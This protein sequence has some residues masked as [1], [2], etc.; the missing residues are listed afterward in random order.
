VRDRI[1]TKAKILGRELFLELNHQ[2]SRTVLVLGSG[3]SGTTW[4]AESLAREHKSRLLFEPFHPLL[5]S[6]DGEPHLFSQPSGKGDTFEQSVE[7]VL[8]GRVRTVHV[9]QV[10]CARLARG[11]IVK[12]VHAANLLPWFRAGYPSLP[13]VFVLR[14]PIAASLSRLRSS[15]FYGLG[16]YLATPAGRADAE[17]SPVASWLP[18][19]D[20]HRAD[21]EP[22]VRLVAEWCIENVHPLSGLD[23]AGAALAFYEAIVISPVTELARLGEH[24]RGAL[25]PSNGRLTVSD[26]RQPSAM[27]WFG[28]AAAARDSD[29]WTQLLSRWT[30]EVPR[31]TVDRCLSVLSDFGL[32]RFYGDDPLPLSAPSTG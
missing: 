28:S 8:S 10:V 27:D 22:L 18:L 25:G 4:L 15:A 20:R 9:D 3:R 24:C 31:S 13:V 12:D 1:A 11:R 5:G 17:G 23:D 2:T 30:D 7:R 26:T 21:S 19:Y 32:D 29:E 6:I 16:D 14:H